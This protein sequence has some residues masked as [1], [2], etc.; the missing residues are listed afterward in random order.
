MEPTIILVAAAAVLI[1][2]LVYVRARRKTPPAQ[3]ALPPE[4]AKPYSNPSG[5]EDGLA[6]AL[7]KEYRWG[8]VDRMDDP[9]WYRKG[10]EAFEF[11]KA[12]EAARNLGGQ[13]NAAENAQPSADVDD[14]TQPAAPFGIEMPPNE[15]DDAPDVP[16]T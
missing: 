12:V 10:V 2:I 9:T 6:D 5:F 7:E 3:A 1:V 15:P 4:L 14:E 11:L 8:Q 13:L 16:S